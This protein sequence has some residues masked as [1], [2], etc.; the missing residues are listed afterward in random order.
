MNDEQFFDLAMKVIARQATEAE[1]A[2]LDALAARQPKLKA[3]FERLQADVRLA[4]E[5]APA[6]QRDRGNGARVARLR[7]RTA[8]N[9]SPRNARATAGARG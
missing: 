6:S 7:A 2:E 3:E 4:R 9:Q 5:A 1:C 8:A